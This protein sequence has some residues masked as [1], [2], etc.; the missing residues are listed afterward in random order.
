[1]IILDTNVVSEMMKE[2]PEQA[3]ANWLDAQNLRSLYVTTI[4]LMELRYA[5][6]LLPEGKRKQALREVL[7]FT[8][9]KLF[10]DRELSFTRH[11]AEATATIAA[12]TK[13]RGVNL[14]IADLQIAGIA[15]AHGFAVVSRDTLPFAEAGVSLINPWDD[16]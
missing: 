11:A 12:E 8:L 5:V 2:H 7:D 16:A 1:M 10:D 13:N 15:M 4:N 14:G 3:V 9:A 6:H